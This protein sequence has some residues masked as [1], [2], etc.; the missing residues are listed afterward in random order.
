MIPA[1]RQANIAALRGNPIAAAVMKASVLK[2][3]HQLKADAE[4][5]AL[6]G[7]AAEALIQHSGQ[8]L[9][10]A[11]HAAEL[12]KLPADMPELRIMRGMAHALGQL[13]EDRSTLEQHRGSIQS[14]LA[15]IERVL[16]KLTAWG[17]GLGLI[18]CERRVALDGFGTQDIG[19]MLG[20]A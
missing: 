6:F 4:L 17:L 2:T 3:V 19:E 11:A 7:D 9:F 1:P 5:Q 14:G 13:A 10:A 15:A 8:L 16:P 12:N 18:E 20:A